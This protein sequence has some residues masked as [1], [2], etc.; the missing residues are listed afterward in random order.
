MNVQEAKRRAINFQY[1][2]RSFQIMRLKREIHIQEIWEGILVSPTNYT[3]C[4]F[5]PAASAAAGLHL[6]FKV[7]DTHQM[8]K[9]PYA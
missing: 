4:I 3:E 6:T 2:L 8:L 1:S 9:M 5:L 7:T